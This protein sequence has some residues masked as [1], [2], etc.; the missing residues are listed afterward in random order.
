LALRSARIA[1][2]SLPCTVWAAAI[3]ARPALVLGPVDLPP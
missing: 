2:V 3:L 1:L